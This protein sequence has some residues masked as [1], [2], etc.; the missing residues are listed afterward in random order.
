M[1]AETDFNSHRYQGGIYCP[2]EQ[3]LSA[4]AEGGLS[5]NVRRK[6]KVHLHVCD[7][8]AE[9][10]ELTQE[11]IAAFHRQ[12]VGISKQRPVVLRPVTWGVA[13]TVLILLG[14]IF[15][16][17]RHTRHSF[18][19]SHEIT[20]QGVRLQWEPP[21]TTDRFIVYRKRGER[22]YV[23]LVG[24]PIEQ[25]N[26]FLDQS[27]RHSQSYSYYVAAIDLQ[28]QR[29]KSDPIVVFLEKV[30]A[31]VEDIG[32]TN[33]AAFE[34]YDGDG[35]LDLYVTNSVVSNRLYQNNGD[36]TF[37]DVTLKAG[38]GNTHSSYR[39]VFGDYDNDGDLDL[40]VTNGNAPNT[41]YENQGDGTFV[42][43]TARA[44]V[45]N[46]AASMSASWA[47]FN[48]DGHLDLYVANH[49]GGKDADYAPSP[50]ALYLNN[51]NGT[52]SELAKS[53]GVRG[54][55]YHS[56]VVCSDLDND[57]DS[58][59][60][61]TVGHRGANLLY[62][63]RLVPEGRLSFREVGQSAGVQEIG[64]DSLGVVSS[65]LDNDGDFDL[66]VNNGA[67]KAALYLNEGD[68]TFTDVA[69]AAGV[70]H[71]DPASSV[72]LADFDNDGF[73]DIIMERTYYL[74]R[75]GEKGTLRFERHAVDHY[76]HPSC[77]DYDNDGDL[78]IYFCRGADDPNVL[79]RNNLY[80]NNWLVVNLV[81][82]KSNR[83]AIGTIVSVESQGMTLM[84]EVV[85]G[86]GLA[87]HESLALEFGLGRARVID[88]L[89]IR[90]P[91]GTVQVL[92]KLQPN[93]I[94]TVTEARPQFVST[95]QIRIKPPSVFHAEEAF[96]PI[97]FAGIH[98]F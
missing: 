17:P 3:T 21:T 35:D 15:F 1:T 89:K 44:G 79:Y 54:T 51:G 22:S 11:A 39:A 75:T 58:D 91:S 18:R 12:S 41:L 83:S 9:E 69:E 64:K 30:T 48:N 95:D 46:L 66:Y 90:W 59:I 85:S 76:G 65:D 16:L 49:D 42:D 45:G 8:C 53:L 88:R 6:V 87:T 93:Q 82:T 28:G 61:I 86:S 32:T 5:D 62:E 14:T 63:N 71:Q 78:D 31:G 36:G 55:A 84:R 43:V 40:Y 7:V 81:G 56:A 47:D 50:N 4:Y 24:Q 33:G 2:D 97:L 23:Q 80:S 96:T 68:G 26:T 27:A 60:Y 13:A 19:I 73:L 34:D 77:G 29:Q 57:G 37:T 52:F 25:Q 70:A 94:I 98:R 38:V 92:G 67:G 74:N 72:S 20:P 10:V